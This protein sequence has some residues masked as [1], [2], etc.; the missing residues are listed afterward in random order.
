MIPGN[1]LDVA[2]VDHERQVELVHRRGQGCLP[3]SKPRSH[4]QSH[5]W[6]GMSNPVLLLVLW[7]R[8][9]GRHQLS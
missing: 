6:A 5:I 8:V 3:L 2:P 9:S 4:F 7:S 1:Q